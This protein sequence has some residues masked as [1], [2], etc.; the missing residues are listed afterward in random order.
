MNKRR[1]ILEAAER[2]FRAKGLT[3][4]TTRE[5]ARDAGCADGT[6]YLHFTDRLALLI[7]VLDETVPDFREPLHL[8]KDLV[9]KRT[10]RL[11]LEMVA[12]ASLGFYEHVQSTLCS[13]FADPE[14][15]EAHRQSMRSQGKGPHI[16]ETILA[17]Y[18][19]G[20]QKIGRIDRRVSPESIGAML[21]GAC[22]YRV[23]VTNYMGVPFTPAREVFIRKLVDELLRSMKPER[24]LILSS[25]RSR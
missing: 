3:G 13:V 16:P 11:N 15:L 25:A 6:L 17:E 12:L 4:A 24:A 7:A 10:I 14:L 2:I 23:F 5:I 20:E 19:R 21:F 22:F 8:L 9:G 18:I 1:Q